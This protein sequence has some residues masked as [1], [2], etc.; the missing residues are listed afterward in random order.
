MISYMATYHTFSVPFGTAVTYVGIWLSVV[1]F[2]ARPSSAWLQSASTGQEKE[3]LNGHT[4]LLQ[5]LLDA[6][7][8]VLVTVIEQR[9]DALGLRFERHAER[10]GR[11]GCS[12]ERVRFADRICN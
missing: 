5:E 10:R 12:G 4:D 8:D 3:V 1:P 7:V 2:S 11:R 9:R 6:L